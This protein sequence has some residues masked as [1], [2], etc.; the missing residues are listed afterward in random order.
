MDSAG[1]RLAARLDSQGETASATI[2]VNLQRWMTGGRGSAT[3]AVTPGRLWW[4][5]SSRPMVAS[6]AIAEVS[7]VRC[8][9]GRSFLRRREA[10]GVRIQSGPWR[11]SV[12]R[13]TTAQQRRTSSQSSA[14][15]QVCRKTPDGRTGSRKA[16]FRVAHSGPSGLPGVCPGRLNVKASSPPACWLASADRGAIKTARDGLLPPAMGA[17]VAPPSPGRRDRRLRVRLVSPTAEL[18][19]RAMEGRRPGRRW[20]KRGH[21][22]SVRAEASVDSSTRGGPHRRD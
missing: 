10:A 20:E 9:G 21:P 19:A 12:S 2:D 7:E 15:R 3:L 13:P 18:G 22:E 1:E 4:S 17:V 5:T 8:R 11:G 6:F 14:I 16:T